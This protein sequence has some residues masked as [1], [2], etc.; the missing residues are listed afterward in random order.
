MEILEVDSTTYA[1]VISSPA[2]IF[3]S[4]AFNALNES[5]CEAVY[6]LLFKDS[7]IRLGIIFGV[8]NN[9][10]TS[11]FSA[12][13][14]G[15]EAINSDIRL[16]QIDAALEALTTW[17]TIKKFTGIKIVAPSFFYNPNFLNKVFNCLYRDNFENKNIEL[18]YQFPTYKIDENYGT[19]IWY[20]ARKNLKR[21][22]N[23]NLTFE[24]L[25]S[26]NGQLAYN[27]IAQNRKERG[28]PLRMTWEQVAETMLV[29]NVDFFLVKKEEDHIGAALLFYVSE[30]IVQVVY[31]GDLPQYSESKT[32]N[33]LSYHVFKY[34]KELG[35]EM[36]DIGPSTEGS[37]PNNGLCEFKESIG[38]DISIKTEFYKKLI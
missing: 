19:K 10:L 33:F 9:I 2:H 17:A 37:I 4:A 32:M 28:F 35:V 6:Y 20:N 30:G 23:D 8:R 5:K 38:C 24:K 1:E 29:I 31:W 25:E 18:N 16:Q 21:A 13:F 34:Y 7:K 12:P 36:I 27:V 14:G 22:L 11:P 3:N 15:F 26:E